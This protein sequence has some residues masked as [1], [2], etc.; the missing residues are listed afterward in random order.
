MALD[1]TTAPSVAIGE[2]IDSRHWNKLADAFNDRFLGG[3]G[4]PTYRLHWYLHSIFRAFRLPADAFNFAAEDEWWK[5]YSHVE[6]LAYDYPALAAGLPEGVNPGNPLGGF[7]FGNEGAGVYNEPDRINYDTGTGDGVLLHDALGAPVS[8]LDH[9]EIGKYQRGVTDSAGTDLDQANALV[10]AQHHLKIRFSGFYHK[11][12]G[13]FLPTSSMTGLCEDGVVSDHTIKFRKLSPETDCTWSSCPEGSGTGTCPGVANGVYTWGISGKNYYLNHWDGTQTLLPLE[14]YIEGPYDGLNDNAFL[15]RTDGDQLSR[16]L[17][18]Y[19]ND[20][21]GNDTQRNLSAYFVEDYAFDFQRFFTR[22]YF[23]APAYGVPSG[24]GDGSLDTV[25]TQFDWNND[26]PAGYGSTG[27]ADNYDIHAGFVC[28]G[29]IAVGDTLTEAKTFTLTVDGV[30]FGSVTIDGTTEDQSVWFEYPKAGNVQISCDKAMGPS[31]SAYCEI[32]ELLEMKPANEDAYIVLRMGSANGTADDGDGHDTSSPVN[33]SDNLWR[34]G[35]I[36]N[37]SR[38]AVRDED[39]YI[40]RNP[41]YMTARKVAHD[42]TRMVE[43]ASLVGYEVSGGK[44]ILFYDR[45]ARGVSGADIFK[46]IAPS[47]DAIASGSIRH[48]T[49]YIVDSGTTGI[50]YNGG[51]VAVGATF[52][53]VKDVNTF[54]KTTGDEVVKEYDGIIATAGA[55]GTDNRWSMFMSTTTYKASDQSIWK[56]DSYGDVIGWGV[57]RCTFYS[58][59]WSDITDNEGKEM[60]QHVTDGGGRPLI[61]PENPSGYRYALGTHSPPVGTAGTLV[62]DS[63]TGDCDFG[64]GTPDNEVDCAGVVNHYESCQVYVP[65]YQVESVIITGTGE[66]KVTLTGRLRANSTAP[67]SVTNSSAGWDTYLGTETGARSDENAVVEYLRWDQGSGTHCTARVGDTAPDAP[68]TG[69]ADWTG[70]M[71]GSCL[72]RFYFT[73]LVQKVYEDSNNIYESHDTRLVTDELTWLDLVLRA[74]CEGYVDQVNTNQLR[75]YFNAISQKD[76]CYTKRLFDYTYENLFSAA[77]NNRW[78][79]LVPL[80][81]RSDNPKMFG[82]LPMVFTYAEHFNQ[83]ARAVNLLTRARLYLPVVLKERTYDYTGQGPVA[84]YGD[85]NCVNGAVW[86]EDQSAPAATTLD[87]SVSPNPSAWSEVIPSGGYL[88]ILSYQRTK[89]DDDGSGNCIIINDRRDTEYVIELS[90]LSS[91]ALPTDLHTLVVN[92]ESVGYAVAVDTQDNTHN[93]IVETAGNGWGAGGVG[94]NGAE[95]DYQDDFGQ[96]QFWESLNTPGTT[97]EIARSGMLTAN[98]PSVSDY[99]DTVQGS[100]GEGANTERNLTVEN[101]EAY[102]KVP[103]V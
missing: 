95:V 35:M 84:V 67:A 2:P 15:R 22:Q 103:L 46:G 96:Y 72:P 76:D 55:E 99:I 102:V 93:R 64:D 73:R 97:C 90:Q 74:I 36:Y 88:T 61:R 38:S 21:R 71:E 29:F 41:I 3:V 37:G 28:A 82:P 54:T 12:Y 68:N 39:T 69:G 27:G 47:E 20:F 11:G 30:T 87:P 5:F 65:D 94:A 51:G 8:D 75:S 9:W 17:N 16:T 89:I 63:N 25:Y 19:S 100:F 34:H 18:F 78:P 58:Q 45:E 48:N 23:L 1:Y 91:N 62:A 26:D 14:D 77:N 6:P 13:G 10:A 31:E 81:E 50:T 7:V 66:V 24:Y 33:I 44:S 53:G 4:D 57:D 80:S 49:T 85:G 59:Q 43:R 60:L 56:P 52:I 86:A 42:R 32:A 79:R 92:D 70:F 83:I 98:L 40:N 101:I